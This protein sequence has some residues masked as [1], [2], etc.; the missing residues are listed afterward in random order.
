MS[1]DK[2]END[3]SPMPMRAMSQQVVPRLAANEFE[4]SR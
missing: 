3:Y 1:Y 2:P 4:P